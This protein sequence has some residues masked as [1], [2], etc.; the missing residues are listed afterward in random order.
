MVFEKGESG[1]LLVRDGGRSGVAQISLQGGEGAGDS[2]KKNEEKQG[3]MFFMGGKTGK[4]L[5]KVKVKDKEEVVKKLDSI[6][7]SPALDKEEREEKSKK[8]N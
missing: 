7:G 5:G 4:S 1:Q 8:G 2:K 6:P 3:E